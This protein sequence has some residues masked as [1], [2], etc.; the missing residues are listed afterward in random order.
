[1]DLKNRFPDLEKEVI[2]QILKEIDKSLYTSSTYT[3]TTDETLTT[4]KL[5]KILKDLQESLPSFTQLD[6]MIQ[7]G[8]KIEELV[9]MVYSEKISEETIMTKY[10]RLT[11]KGIPMFDREC[12]Y[13]VSKNPYSPITLIWE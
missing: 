7:E 1:M 6:Q 10:G 9:L 11:I 8:H 4:E 3:T 2:S 13:L 5:M 12:A